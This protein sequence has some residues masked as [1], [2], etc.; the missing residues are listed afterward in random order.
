MAESPGLPDAAQARLD[1]LKSHPEGLIVHRV[2]RHGQI[3][4]AR[5]GPDIVMVF[6][7]L[8]VELSNDA[9]SG[10]MARVDP[11]TP[12]VLKGAYTQAMLACLSFVPDPGRVY[13]MG[14]GGGRVPMVLRWLVDVPV[15][16]GSELDKDVLNLSAE[17]LGFEMAGGLSIDCAEGRAH[18][19]AQPD[20]Q[21]DHIYVD[22]YGADARV[23]PALSTAE[24]FAMIRAKLTHGGV[25]A[26]NLIAGDERFAAQQAGMMQAFSQIW[27]WS[28]GG[29]TVLFG[30][31]AV[32]SPEE[33]TQA[34]ADLAARIPFGFDL[35]AHIDA[36][37]PV[38][39]QDTPIHD[40]EV[41]DPAQTAR[42]FPKGF[43]K[44]CARNAPCPCGSGY[45]FKGCHGRR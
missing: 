34:A 17:Y 10:V 16:M 5:T 45:K 32:S 4:I 3:A 36:L 44:G 14:A 40:A 37:V 13:V 33:R 31:D 38:S 25:M 24:F 41:F 21:F 19:T 2:G 30:S 15:V 35:P 43:F 18:L 26:M 27:A 20:G 9:L 11:T 42:F 23:P 6:C 8:G 29:S 1:R 28:Q 7:P 39:V 12:L 22:C